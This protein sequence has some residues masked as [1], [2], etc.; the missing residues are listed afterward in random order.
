MRA[1][2]VFLNEPCYGPSQVWAIA[3]MVLVWIKR[4][5]LGAS[6]CPHWILSRPWSMG[7]L[8]RLFP[9]WQ[10]PD[11]DQVKGHEFK[12][13]IEISGRMSCEEMPMLEISPLQEEMLKIEMPQQLR[14]LLSFMFVTDPEARPSA[15]DVL[16]SDEFQ[17]FEKSVEE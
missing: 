4:E 12:A 2:E 3:A 11:P 8:R 5:I 1:P 15:A 9:Q 7:K 14:E 16:A 10:L 6:D 17:A 13:A